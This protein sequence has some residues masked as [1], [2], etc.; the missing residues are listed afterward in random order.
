MRRDGVDNE[1]NYGLGLAYEFHND[2][3]GVAFFEAGFFKDSGRNWAKLV[4]PGYQFKLDKKWRLGAALLLLDSG[5]YN[6]G[7]AFVTPI[8]MLTHDMG[9]VKLNAIYA[10][11]FQRYNNFAVF[12]FYISVPWAL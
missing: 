5:T 3:D 8:P 10:P 1:R 11:H 7:R 9:A 2:A 12:G 6:R 4:G